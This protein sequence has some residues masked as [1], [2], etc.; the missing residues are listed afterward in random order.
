MDDAELEKQFA[1]EVVALEQSGAVL[2]LQFKPSEAWMLLALLQAALR[3][4]GIDAGPESVGAFGKT[5][6]KNIEGRLCRTPAMQEVARR[7]WGQASDLKRDDRAAVE[8][9]AAQ[10]PPEP[11]EPPERARPVKP[12]AKRRS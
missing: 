7:G 8:R 6:A 3:R 10:S 2:P 5:L 12:P 1:A 11:P 4:P 9:P